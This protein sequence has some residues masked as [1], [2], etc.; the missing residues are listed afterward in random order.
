MKGLPNQLTLLRLALAPCY[1]ALV[2][3]GHAWAT[4]AAAAMVIAALITDWLDGYLA[5]RWNQLSDFG[6]CFDPIADK[7]FVL[8]ALTALAGLPATQLPAAPLVI[9]ILRELLMTGFRVVIL[10]SYRQVVAAERFGKMKTSLQFIFIAW[11]TWLLLV[12]KIYDI[13]YL[14]HGGLNIFFWMVAWVTL[15]SALPY[16]WKNWRLL[17]DS[18]NGSSF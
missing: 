17:K 6:A 12:D 5:R 1:A 9:I 4:M 14:S 18:W 15:L 3:S 2:L 16:L 13:N 7:A 8:S 11:V 10:I